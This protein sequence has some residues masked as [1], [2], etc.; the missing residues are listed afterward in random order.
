MTGKPDMVLWLSDTR[1]VYIPRDFAKCFSDRD[2]AVAG[3][4]AEQWAILEDPDHDAY[5]D[6]WT[7]VCDRAVV[8]DNE[9]IKFRLHQDG[10]LWLVP[11][12]MEWSDENQTF[13]WPG[14]ENDETR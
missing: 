14:D 1:G 12:G 9:G 3:V 13:E 6:V 8:T 11:E 2:K 10:D 5:W 7:E 4:S